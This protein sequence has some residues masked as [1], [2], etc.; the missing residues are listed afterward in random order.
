M[1]TEIAQTPKMWESCV[2]SKTT[3]S[4]LVDLDVSLLG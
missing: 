3:Y 1:D 2:N 4:N